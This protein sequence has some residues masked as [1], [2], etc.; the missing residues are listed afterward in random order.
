MNFKLSQLLSWIT[1]IGLG[2]AL[3]IS[4]LENK[5]AF[6]DGYNRADTKYKWY[7]RFYACHSPD[8]TTKFGE[9]LWNDMGA[10]YKDGNLSILCTAE[11]E[12]ENRHDRNYTEQF[13]YVDYE[14]DADGLVI[15]CNYQYDENGHRKLDEHGNPMLKGQ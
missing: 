7:L 9:N 15:K 2:L 13:A 10:M 12:W 3:T 1:I 11:E 4:R 5:A 6:I 14:Y 8:K